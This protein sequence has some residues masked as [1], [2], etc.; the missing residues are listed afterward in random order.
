[1]TNSD[2]D[3]LREEWKTLY[4]QTLPKLAKARDPAQPRWP[5]T[6]DHCFARIILD[7]VVGDGKQQW[8]KVTPKPAVRSMDEKQLNDAIAL[9]LKI[10]GGE[11]DLCQLDEI[12]LRCRGKNEAKYGKSSTEGVQ[13]QETQLLPSTGRRKRAADDV[14]GDGNPSPKRTRKELDRQSTL[15]SWRT[16]ASENVPS[17][18]SKENH[19][20]EKPPTDRKELQ[21]Q[22]ERIQ[23][24]PSLTPYRKRLYTILLSVPQGRYTTYA[25]MSDYL[26]SSARAVGSGMRNNPFAPEVPCHRVLAANGEIGGFHGDWG[27]NGKHAAKKIELLRGEGV[28]FDSRGK[29]VGEPFRRFHEFQEGA[30][31][32]SP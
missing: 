22:L 17:T 13:E 11:V 14:E 7:N 32:S 5:I 25:A 29:V 3:A 16:Q 8:D 27:K 6:L 30:L 23:S 19:Q 1:M 18:T 31:D 28:R 26:V 24:H 20:L 2:I 12:S 15:D 9:G 4:S 21:R 10:I